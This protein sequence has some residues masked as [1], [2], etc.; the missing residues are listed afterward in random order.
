M[1]QVEEVSLELALVKTK[2][3]TRMCTSSFFLIR[4]SRILRKPLM[5][6]TRK[7][8]T[9][10]ALDDHQG[11]SRTHG[12]LGMVDEVSTIFAETSLLDSMHMRFSQAML[13]MLNLAS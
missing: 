3:M 5:F 1:V 12:E 11:R 13:G 4:P 9:D 10:I 8:V 2:M 6:G 7:G